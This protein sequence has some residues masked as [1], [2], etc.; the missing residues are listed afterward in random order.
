MNR[1][2]KFRCWNGQVMYQMKALLIDENKYKQLKD[3]T[4]IIMQYTGLKDNNGKDIYEGD[5]LY[6]IAIDAKCRVV[7][8]CYSTMRD[9]WGIEE[10]SPKFCV[11]WS[12]DSGYSPI[13]EKMEIIGN[14]YENPELLNN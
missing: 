1:E 8:G 12:D 7:F 11:L 5:I 9:G 2:L 13:Q 6:D 4:D 10:L 14:I 3:N